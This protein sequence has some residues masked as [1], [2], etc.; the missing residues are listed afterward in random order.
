M[1]DALAR[2]VAL[3]GLLVGGSLALALPADAAAATVPTYQN[4]TALNQKYKHGVGRK[5]ARDKVRGSTKPVTTFTVNTALY[6]ANK[7]MDRDKDGVACE[8][9]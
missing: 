3:T 8:K 6:N 5:G 2:G 9:R 1:I 4:C 7:R